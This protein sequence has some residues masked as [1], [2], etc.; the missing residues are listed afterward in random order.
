MT[1][2]CTH[3]AFL[4][5]SAFLGIDIAKSTFEVVLVTPASI[6]IPASKGKPHHKQFANTQA[7]CEKLS[8]WLQ[9][10]GTPKVHACKVHACLEATGIYGDELARFLHQSGQSVSVVNPARIKAFAQSQL[11]RNKTDKADA[12]LIAHFCQSQT[13]PLWSPPDPMISELQ[14]LTRHLEALLQ[15]QQQQKNRQEAER[16]ATVKASLQSLIDYLGQEIERLKQQIQDHIDQHPDLKEQQT[17]LASIPG[18]GCLTAAK[19]LGEVTQFRVYDNA[20]Q[21]AAYA[22]LTPRQH[23]SGTS[24]RGQ[25]GLSK[26]GNRR[27]RKALYMP[28]LVAMRFNPVIQPFCQRLRDR[29][30]CSMVIVGAVMRKLLHLAYGVLKSGQ[31]FNPNYLQELGQIPGNGQ[32]LAPNA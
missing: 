29:G 21:V 25:T 32:K 3:S 26:I 17:L 22:G 20:R 5:H 23:Q 10:R 9:E 7:G 16:S 2:S 19:L 11:S 24:V 6:V 30:K 31:P 4:D 14:A 1:D 8:A 27:V 18:I 15:N 13:P 28:A 12:A